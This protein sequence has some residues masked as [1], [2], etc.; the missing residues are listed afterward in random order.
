MASTLQALQQQAEQTQK[1]LQAMTFNPEA[2]KPI[3]DALPSAV[4]GMGATID[5]PPGT[6]L[7][8]GGQILTSIMHSA[9]TVAE[10]VSRG[11]GSMA[12][13]GGSGSWSQGGSSGS[14]PSGYATESDIQREYQTLLEMGD[15][16]HLSAQE[17]RAAAEYNAA[18]VAQFEWIKA[19]GI[20]QSTAWESAIHNA[21]V[22]QAEGRF[23]SVPVS[24]QTPSQYQQ[25]EG[26]L[27]IG[28]DW[29]LVATQMAEKTATANWQIAVAPAY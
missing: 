24:S 7:D 11:G 5:L 3:A 10:V 13:S 12:A 8:C 1:S 23:G 18:T 20:N 26:R 21:G 9:Q 14:G 2:A 19:Q 25:Q 27:S 22:L 29:G 6:Q 4:S 28:L 16:A 15:Y 17:L